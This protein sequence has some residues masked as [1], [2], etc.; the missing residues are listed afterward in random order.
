MNTNLCDA[1]KRIVSE[2]GEAVLDD[3]KQ[4]NALL[5]QYAPND[6]KPEKRALVT[7]LMNGYHKPLKQSTDGN[8]LSCKI[9]LAQKLR[10]GEGIDIHLCKNAIDIME[11]IFFGKVTTRSQPSA[12]EMPPAPPAP[13]YIPPA[14]PADQPAKSRKLKTKHIVIAA[15]ALVVCLIGLLMSVYPRETPDEL[16]Q[17]GNLCF[18]NGDYKKAIGYYGRVIKTEPSASVYYSR[19]MTYSELDNYSAAIGDFSR[20]IDYKKDYHDAY[21][22]RAWNYANIQEYDRAISDLNYY[23]NSNQSNQ[24]AFALLG[25][26][27]TNTGNYDNAIVAYSSA[28]T[29]DPNYI[30]AY[31]FRGALYL[32]AGKYN[33]AAQDFNKVLKIDPSNYDA[34][35]YLAAAKEAENAEDQAMIDEVISALLSGEDAYSSL[36]NFGYQ[37]GL[38]A[39]LG[40]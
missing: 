1:V 35:T 14:I 34:K 40:D 5:A 38:K 24:Y 20:A 37:F 28:I 16:F 21:F 17:K 4:L 15:A 2:K 39:I 22:R 18:D 3:T 31:N 33:T 25:I 23:V 32:N 27:Y 11:S 29:I 9:S 8:R 12:P 19:G 36:Y 26:A 30:D 7:F 6:P 10:D 13:S